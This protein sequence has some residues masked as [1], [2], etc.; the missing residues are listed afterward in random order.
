MG[1]RRG[2]ICHKIYSPILYLILVQ[3]MLPFPAFRRRFVDADKSYDRLPVKG[4]QHAEGS[5]PLMGVLA[6]VRH[7]ST[8][9]SARSKGNPLCLL[10]CE[11][12]ASSFAL[13]TAQYYFHSRPDI[14]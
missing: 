8:N 2:Y 5:L 11:V 7:Q 14:C 13:V 1:L 6:W 10:L 3:C 9:G 4:A 12:K